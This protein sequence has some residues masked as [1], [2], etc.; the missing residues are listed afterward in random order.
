MNDPLASGDGF[1]SR[2]FL[3]FRSA[4]TLIPQP[5]KA[6]PFPTLKTTS[7]G[8]SR[9]SASGGDERGQCDADEWLLASN[10]AG[11]GGKPFYRLEMSFFTGFR[12][13]LLAKSDDHACGKTQ[14]LNLRGISKRG[15]P[16]I[17]GKA[18]SKSG[19]QV[20][21]NRNA[22]AERKFGTAGPKPNQGSGQP[23]TIAVE[24]T[25]CCTKEHLPANRPPFFADDPILRA[26]H[27]GILRNIRLENVVL[28]ETS[29]G[30]SIVAAEISRNSKTRA[31]VISEA[32]VPGGFIVVLQ[33]VARPEASVAASPIDLEL[34][35]IGF[36]DGTLNALLSP[37]PYSGLCLLRNSRLLLLWVLRPLCVLLL[38]CWSAGGI[39]SYQLW[40]G[41][42]NKKNER[43]H[44]ASETLAKMHE[45]ESLHSYIPPIGGEEPFVYLPSIRAFLLFPWSSHCL[46]IQF[47]IVFSARG[48]A[49]CVASSQQLS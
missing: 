4:V 34:V 1:A 9:F 31:D 11:R 7:T 47:W 28:I 44:E 22:C 23:G 2:K 35:A 3:G 21:I 48:S 33:I 43:T 13:L 17:W 40:G 36:L 25:F 37:G 30:R 24:D 10:L 8:F 18:N 5:V 45:P 42:K 46:A 14:V 20:V 16:I 41:K 32:S 27:E 26:A 6:V 38:G 29:E 39:L 15:Q 12:K 49:V 19:R